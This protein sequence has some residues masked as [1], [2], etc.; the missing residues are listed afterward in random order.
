MKKI[1][2]FT[3]IELMVVISIIAIMASIILGPVQTAKIKGRNLVRKKQNDVLVDALISYNSDHGFYPAGENNNS[4]SEQGTVFANIDSNL[5]GDFIP[6]LLTEKYIT[7]TIRDPLY[8]SDQNYMI[9][10]H[11][12]YPAIEF[13]NCTSLDLTGDTSLW[14]RVVLLTKY[15]TGP[16]P[17]GTKKCANPIF[18]CT[19]LNK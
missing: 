4:V 19:C 17:P 9:Y 18:Y 3:L 13:V 11:D 10:M 2:G 7:K 15:E 12:G 14:P 6:E 16:V 5:D 8:P 1:K